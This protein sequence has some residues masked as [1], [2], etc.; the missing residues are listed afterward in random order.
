MI[1]ALLQYISASH[2]LEN[3]RKTNGTSNFRAKRSAHRY[4]EQMV[5]TYLRREVERNYQIMCT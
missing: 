1:K 2:K 3:E 4:H 5:F